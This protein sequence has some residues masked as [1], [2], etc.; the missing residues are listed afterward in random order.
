LDQLAAVREHRRGGSLGSRD[1]TG[2]SRLPLPGQLGRVGVEA[3]ADLAAALGY[4][5]REPIG[6]GLQKVSR[7]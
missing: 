5:R 3:E 4:Q 2:V 7:P 1:A 6:K